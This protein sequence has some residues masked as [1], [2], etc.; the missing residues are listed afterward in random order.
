VLAAI[1]AG[2]A[3]L[4]VRYLRRRRSPAQESSG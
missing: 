1:A 4:A 3:W 2:V